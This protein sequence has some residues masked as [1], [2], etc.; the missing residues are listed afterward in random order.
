MR[1]EVKSSNI[2]SVDYN[3]QERFLI[4]EFSGGIKYKYEKVQIREYNDFI[5]AESKGKFFHKRIKSN[6]TW[7]KLE[8]PGQCVACL[9]NTGN[10]C[11]VNDKIVD[12]FGSCSQ[13]ESIPVKNVN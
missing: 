5:N 9:F 11:S 12:N 7:K 3:E 6:Y 1:I 8:N 13:F 4:V 2:T 10:F